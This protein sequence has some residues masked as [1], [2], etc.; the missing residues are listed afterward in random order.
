MKQKDMTCS[1]CG[2]LGCVAHNLC[3]SCYQRKWLTGT[4]EY[5]KKKHGTNPDNWGENTRR[6]FTMYK[7]GVS[8]S[9][10]ARN[11]GISRQRVGQI[12]CT[13]GKK[14]N[15][16]RLIH[17]SMQELADWLVMNGNGEDYQTWLSWLQQEAA[18]G[19][20]D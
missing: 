18:D 5:K 2:K 11:L 10:I 13:Y 20:T 19:Q 12:I 16:Y 7:S 1:C 14:I 9:D 15:Y 3:H 4:L 6:V 8:Q 17:M